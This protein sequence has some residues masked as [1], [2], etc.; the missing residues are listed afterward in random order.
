MKEEKQETLSKRSPCEQ[1]VLVSIPVARRCSCHMENLEVFVC[2][3]Q[4]RKPL[5]FVLTAAAHPV[6]SQPIEEKA[7]AERVAKVPLGGELEGVCNHRKKGF[8]EKCYASLSVCCNCCISAASPQHPALC[9]VLGSAQQL[10]KLYP[11][12]HT[13]LALASPRILR[14][15]C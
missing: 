3:F 8:Q 7:E 1:S 12:T 9:A 10:L 14:W 4:P 13:A 6:N 5:V 2:V 15:D 11:S